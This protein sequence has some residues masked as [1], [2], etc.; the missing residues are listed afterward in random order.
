MSSVNIGQVIPE[1]TAESTHGEFSSSQIQGKPT[2]I[3]FY[4]RDNTPGCTTEAQDFRDQYAKFKELGCEIYGIS[5]DTM[6]SHEKFSD[7]QELPF[8]LIADPEEKICNL[9]DV[10]KQKNMYGKQVRGIER[11]TF[12]FDAN[13][14][15]IQEW[16]KV[17]VPEHVNVVLQA[18][19]ELVK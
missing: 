4:P 8:A 9:F 17:K 16:R 3:Y 19:Q 6:K 1:F 14:Q 11:S 2:I 15:L 12:L 5:R 18:V 10:M 13:A 7:K